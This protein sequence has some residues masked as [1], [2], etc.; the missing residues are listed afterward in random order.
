MRLL[1]APVC[2]LPR[3][4]STTRH[5][6]RSQPCVLPC[7]LSCVAVLFGS[8]AGAAQA[9]AIDPGVVPDVV[10]DAAADVARDAAATASADAARPPLD[11]SNAPAG[12]GDLPAY[13]R[14]SGSDVAIQD[15]WE[16]YNRRI[17][18]FNTMIDKHVAAPVARVYTRR[19]PQ[20]VRTGVTNFFRNLQ[21]V[22]TSLN[23]LLQGHSAASARSLGR[24]AVN[25]TVGIAGVR[26]PATG[27]HLLRYQ[28]DFGQTMAVWGWHRS[29]YFLLPFLGP[30]TLRDD[31]GRLVDSQASIVTYVQPTAVQGTLIGVS[32]VDLRSRALELDQLQT[33]IDDPYALFRDAWGQYRDYQIAH[34]AGESASDQQP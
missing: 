23:L 8:L 14:A 20:V 29:R 1:N 12:D 24:F 30:G 5:L 6:Q 13:L 3:N 4:L 21:L 7:T 34:A 25:T 22:P 2:I 9:Q 33:G 17:F 28:E 26:D 10:P 18:R 32:L 15:P 11:A 31:L 19:V 27:M 16:R